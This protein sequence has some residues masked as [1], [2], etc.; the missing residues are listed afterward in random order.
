MRETSCVAVG[1]FRQLSVYHIFMAIAAFITIVV[2]GY[3]ALDRPSNGNEGRCK[4][5]SM[6]CSIL[7]GFVTMKESDSVC[8][9]MHIE[10]QWSLV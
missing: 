8:I 9:G 6:E 7:E 5:R 10:D 1:C 3:M 4:S 2:V